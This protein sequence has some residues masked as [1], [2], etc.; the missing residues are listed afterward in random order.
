MCRKKDRD[1]EVQFKELLTL[2]GDVLNGSK[3]FHIVNIPQLGYLS[4]TGEFLPGEDSET[5]LSRL[6]FY[7]YY[8]S[9]LDM[10]DGLMEN[11]RWQWYM[12][13]N[14][15]VCTD[16]YES[17]LEMDAELLK[18]N[19]PDYFYMIEYYVLEISKVL[20]A[21]YKESKVKN[22]SELF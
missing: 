3:D 16:D 6:L 4:I 8:P 22:D 14:K 12:Q 5:V 1:I 7:Q 15:P 18:E 17:I 13:N 21:V 2:F 10:A 19:Y 9:P 20:G 11:L